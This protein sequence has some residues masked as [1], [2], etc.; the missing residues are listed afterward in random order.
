MWKKQTMHS[1]K[2]GYGP[3]DFAKNSATRLAKQW[4]TIV[5]KNKKRRC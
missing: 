5:G 3:W 4:E 1:A 2:N